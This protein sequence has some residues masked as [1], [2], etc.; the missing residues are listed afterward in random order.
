MTPLLP[1]ST[2]KATGRVH[3]NDFLAVRSVYG[4]PR[5]AIFCIFLVFFID[6][7]TA[8]PQD[9]ESRTKPSTRGSHGCREWGSQSHSQFQNCIGKKLRS[10]LMEFSCKTRFSLTF[11]LSYFSTVFF[12]RSIFQSTI[13]NMK[14]EKRMGKGISA[15]ANGFFT[16]P[17]LR[18]RLWKTTSPPRH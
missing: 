2:A 16:S 6:H 10:C 13:G 14:V 15:A 4:F 9:G 11:L 7:T 3:R 18:R 5:I 1:L 17:L 8:S 12:H